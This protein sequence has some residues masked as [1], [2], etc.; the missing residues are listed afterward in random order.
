MQVYMI[1]NGL[2]IS[3]L[4]KK[5][6]IVQ[7]EFT[8]Q[9]RQITTL[10]GYAEKSEVVKRRIVV[11]FMEVRDTKW[12]EVCMALRTRPVIVQYIDDTVGKTTKVFH[13]SSI[14][15]TAQTVTGGNTYFTGGTFT[16]EEV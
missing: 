2:D 7:S 15:A 12:Y 6:G 4:I 14:S 1:T 8:R 11:R 13:I 16:L 3:A 9:K 5:G 10:D